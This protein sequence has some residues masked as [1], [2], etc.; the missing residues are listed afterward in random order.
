MRLLH[1]IA[2]IVGF[3]LSVGTAIPLYADTS[4][5]SSTD[6]FLSLGAQ[7]QSLLGGERRALQALP[8]G[9]LRQLGSPRSQPRA[10]RSIYTREWLARQPTP[11]GNAEWHCLSEALYFEARGE[12]LEGQ[13]AVAEV[14]LNRKASGRY[15]DSIC[16]VV[17]EGTGRKHACQ[18]SYTCDGKPE[19]VTEMGAW[20]TVGKVARAVMDGAPRLLDP[21]VTHYHT[22]SVNPSWALQY[23]RTNHIGTHVFYR[24]YYPGRT[25]S[26]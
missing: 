11:R 20:D 3:S 4:V 5:S 7:M 13:A 16:S 6:P 9:H 1:T 22:T 23:E 18:F 21:D 15:P 8:E 19:A 10:T 12:S 26:N 17:N 2:A 24:Q 14:I 25:A